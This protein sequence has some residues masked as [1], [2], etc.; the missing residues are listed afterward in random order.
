MLE[1]YSVNLLTLVVQSNLKTK[2]SKEFSEQGKVKWDVYI[3]YAK[4]SNLLAVAIYLTM[5]L[6][7]QTATIGKISCG[8]GAL[9]QR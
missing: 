8:V 7:A 1:A 3:E 4:T 2:Q 6:G 5:L 9:C